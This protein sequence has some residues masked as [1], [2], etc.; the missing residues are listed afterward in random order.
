M[1][2]SKNTSGPPLQSLFEVRSEG[3]TFAASFS[4]R[5]KEGWANLRAR[6]RSYPKLSVC[7]EL[8]PL[9]LNYAGAVLKMRF[10]FVGKLLCSRTP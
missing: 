7:E 6:H 1:E 8:P 2:L 4:A 5:A 3:V 10:W 9:E